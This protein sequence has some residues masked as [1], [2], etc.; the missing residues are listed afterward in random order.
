MK[1]I[2]K[3]SLVLVVLLC[4]VNVFAQDPMTGKAQDFVSAMSRGDFQKAYLSLNSDLGFKVKPGDLQN[5]WSQIVSWAGKFVEF[6]DSKIENKNDYIIVTSVCKFEKGLVDVTV[7]L[8]SMGKVAG[9]NTQGH[10][11]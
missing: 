4:A 3:V 7:A 5:K 9:F 2:F 8:D 6:K 11:A 1:S 10:K